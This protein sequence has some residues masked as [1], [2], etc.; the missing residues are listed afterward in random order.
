MEAWSQIKPSP[1]PWLVERMKKTIEAFKAAPFW[2][3]D[4]GGF[5]P[6][7]RAPSRAIRAR[8]EA[9]SLQGA[10]MREGSN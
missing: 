1:T 9:G 4:G 3:K 2:Q 10:I 5:I 7:P 8:K 6:C